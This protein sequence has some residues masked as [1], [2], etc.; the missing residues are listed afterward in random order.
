MLRMREGKDLILA[1]KPYAHEDRSK[2]WAYT[3]S[4][5]LLLLA[6]FSMALI[7]SPLP[8]RILGSLL[9]GLLLLR[10]FM[11]YHDF[12]HKA[13]LKDSA[14]ANVIFTIY[15]LYTLNPPSIWKRSHDYHHKHN[16]KLHTSSI[17]SFPIVTAE[18]F[19]SMT[20]WERTNYLFIRHPLTIAAGYIFAFTWGMCLL[21]L[22]RN[23]SK[24]W[25]SA[26]ALLF[27]YGIGASIYISFGGLAFILAFLIP[28]IISSG[29]GSYLFYAQHNFPATTFEEKDD[30]TY[31]KAAMESSSFM[32]MNPIMQ[33]FTGNIGYHHIHHINVLI[34]FYRLT[35]VQAAFP[36]FQQAKTTSL[37]PGE[38]WRCLQIKVWDANQKRMI[39]LSE[40]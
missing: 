7:P 26:L 15:G 21:S 30:W 36:E 19:K 10:M 9:T 8:F 4:T 27:H 6:S 13:I 31:A 14:I 20:K 2:S 12:L 23:P 5:V 25:D 39:K 22:I 1:T 40:I 33:W 35:E 16:S 28:A 29:I 24:H 18:K 34:P 38:I 17:G 32:R 37:N 3:L 11:L